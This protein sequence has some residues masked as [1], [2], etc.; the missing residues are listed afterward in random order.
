M[1]QT[2]PLRIFVDVP[3]SAAG[4]LMNAGVPAEIR[5]TGA[6]GGV[7]SGKIA[8]SAESINAQAR[9]MRVEVDMPERQ[10]RAGARNVRQRRLSPAASR[11]GRSSRSRADFPRDRHA[12]G[13]KGRCDGK[14]QFEDVT[15]ARDNG[16]WSNCPS[17]RAARAIG[18][19]STS[20][21]RSRG[22]NG[23]VAEPGAAILPGWEALKGAMKRFA[24]HRRRIADRG[25]AACAAGP[26]YRT[27]K[28]DMPPSSL[29]KPRPAAN[30]RRRRGRARVDL[31]SWWRA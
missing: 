4:E 26:N 14:I 18:S 22:T 11:I 10:P 28:S 21:A 1:A 27:P 5:A 31:A 3:Q 13:A 20:A 9:T 7:F 12:G 6:V 24:M 15:I 23:R 16:S 2:D 25:S 17:G 8:R 19:C 29:R 30:S